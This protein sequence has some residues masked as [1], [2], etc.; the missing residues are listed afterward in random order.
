MKDLIIV[1]SGNAAREYLQIAKDVN[2]VSPTWRIKGFISDYGVDVN[3]LTNGEYQL[4]GSIREWVPSDNEVFVCSISE[5][6]GKKS[7]VESLLSRGAVFVDLLH[8]TA[9][10]GDYVQKGLG[11]VMY[12]YASIGVNSN[13]GNFVTVS[14]SIAHDNDIGDYVTL[15][16]GAAL[17][18]NVTVGEC[19]FF[20]AKIVVAPKVKIGNNAFIGIGSVVVSNVKP[21]VRVFGN[22]ARKIDF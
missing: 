1:G 10:I 22:P 4:L 6:T 8:P 21:N 19:A 7:V 12:P 5:P 15:S 20:G 9:R 3:K 16:G 2:K 18:G 13:V 11:L 14:G 17:S